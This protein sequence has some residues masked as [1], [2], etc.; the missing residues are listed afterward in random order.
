MIGYV[1]TGQEHFL[2]G[3]KKHPITPAGRDHQTARSPKDRAVAWPGTTVGLRPL[4][5]P[6]QATSLIQIVALVS[7]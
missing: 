7:S 2:F 5:V 4:S 1:A 3:E 6:G